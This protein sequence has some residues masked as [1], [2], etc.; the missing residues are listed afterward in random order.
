MITKVHGFLGT[1]M[2]IKILKIVIMVFLSF[3]L[4]LNKYKDWAKNN[5]N[6]SNI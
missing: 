6:L 2:H 5:M 3:S 1:D 4:S